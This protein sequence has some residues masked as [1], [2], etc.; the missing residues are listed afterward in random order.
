MSEELE[1]A[2]SLRDKTKKQLDLYD[3]LIISLSIKKIIPDFFDD[4]SV[5][6]KK[7]TIDLLSKNGDL[8]TSKSIYL[9]CKRRLYYNIKIND[10]IFPASDIPDDLWNHVVEQHKKQKLNNYENAN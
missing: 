5:D 7:Y 4:E 9:L 8:L 2:K 10:K 3:K 6:S 1:L